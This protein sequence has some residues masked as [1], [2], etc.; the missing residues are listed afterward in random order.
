MRQIPLLGAIRGLRSF[1]FG[2]IAFLI[3]L[4][5]KQVGFSVVEIGIYALVATIASSGLVLLS[6]F[7]GDLYSKKKTLLIMSGL[8]ALIF[9]TFLLTHNFVLLFLTSVLGITFSA[10]GGGAGGGPVAPIL[11]AFVAD[12]VSSASRTWIYSAL[13]L[14]SIISA[15]AGSSTSAVF[16]KYVSDY[17]TDLFAIA[18]ILNIASL[19]LTLLLEDTKIKRVKGKKTQIMPK[20]SGRNIAKIGLSGAMGSVG[21]GVITPIISLWFHQ[22]G[23]P[24]YVISIIFTAS[25]VASGVGVLF[26]STVERWLGAIY[27]IG[28]FRG[29]GSGLFILMPFVP[30]MVAGAIYAIRTGL[31]QLALPIRQNF[32]MT[33]LDPGERAR[34]NSLTGIARRLPYGVSTTFGSFLLSAGAIVFMF[35]FAGIVSL[36]DPILYVYFFRKYKKENVVETAT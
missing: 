32:Q 12:K 3:P 5:L 22:I 11:T 20:N 13:M 9:V 18:L 30:P 35:S 26:A 7:M 28:I 17:Y 6:G 16:E 14:V 10:I 27:A 29:L 2:Y 36:F 19:F 25:Y 8:P 34:G 1:Y 24:T 23:V 31:Y 33:I 15:I 21:L 4:F